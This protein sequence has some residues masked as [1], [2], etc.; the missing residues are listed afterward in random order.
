MLYSISKRKSVLILELCLMFSLN[1]EQDLKKPKKSWM[2]PKKESRN[3]TITKEICCWLLLFREEGIW[4]SEERRPL[5]LPKLRLNCFLSVVS[6]LLWNRINSNNWLRL[7]LHAKRSL[8]SQ[9]LCIYL[10]VD[11]LCCSLWPHLWDVMFLT[12]PVMRSLPLEIV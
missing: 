3:L 6:F 5:V 2:K 9:D 7:F 10:D 11:I 12:V 1:L 8:I 4:I